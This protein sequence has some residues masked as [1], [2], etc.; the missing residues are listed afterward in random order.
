MACGPRATSPR[1]G[2]KQGGLAAQQA[3]AAAAAI[4]ALATGEPLPPVEPPVLRGALVTGTGTLYLRHEHGGASEA[5]AE[6]LWWPPAKV[7]AAH[8]GHYLAGRL[9]RGLTRAVGRSRSRV[10]R[11]PVRRT[12]EPCGRG[13]RSRPMVGAWTS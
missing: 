9:V 1:P 5:S 11:R 2:P 3:A 4:A 8:L 6:P 13:A 12:T 7:A 10:S